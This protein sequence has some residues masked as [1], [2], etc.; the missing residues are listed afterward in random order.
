MLSLLFEVA[1]AAREGT[2]SEIKGVIVIQRGCQKAKEKVA[3]VT[4]LANYNN[5][6]LP[7]NELDASSKTIRGELISN[8]QLFGAA[9]YG[10]GP[11][12]LRKHNCACGKRFSRVWRISC[13]PG[14]VSQQ[15][16]NL[17]KLFFRLC[18]AG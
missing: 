15:R 3:F 11:L 17:D 10:K 2:C 1:R 13:A 7:G 14:P 18:W 12:S 8:R 4:P 6:Q 9:Y 16:Q 5:V